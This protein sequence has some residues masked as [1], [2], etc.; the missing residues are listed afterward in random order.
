MTNKERVMYILGNIGVN[1]GMSSHC[2]QKSHDLLLEA[3]NEAEARGMERAAG[4]CESEKAEYEK[5]MVEFDLKGNT[6]MGT[7][8]ARCASTCQFVAEEI[9]K[10]AKELG[11]GK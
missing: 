10:A 6:E 5:S 3:L 7:N 11:E 9:R 8:E 2:T 1:E 4:I